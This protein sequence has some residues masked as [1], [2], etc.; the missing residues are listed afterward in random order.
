MSKI[1]TADWGSLLTTKS[2]LIG[3]NATLQW[4]DEVVEHAMFLDYYFEHAPYDL[5][6]RSRWSEAKAIFEA[7]L[8]MSSGV[9]LPQEVHGTLLSN[10]ILPRPPKGKHL[11]I[12]QRE[13]IEGAKHIKSVIEKNPTIEYIFVIGLQ[14]NY[15]LQRCGLYSCGEESESFL[16]GAE[17][18]RVGLTSRDPFYQPVDAKPFRKICFNRY[19]ATSYTGVTVIPILPI[20]SYPLTGN[21]LEAFGENYERLKASFKVE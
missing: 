15:Y 16:R 9:V 2:L 21:D 12:P 8:D 3:E 5:G 19:E 1:K 18:R 7:L 11:L 10:E 17:P 20:K 14:A 4:K 6:E 13:A